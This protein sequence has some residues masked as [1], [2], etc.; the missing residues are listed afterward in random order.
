LPVLSLA[1]MLKTY[2]LEGILYPKTGVIKR[3]VFLAD[4]QKF[5]LLF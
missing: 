1:E 2:I 4:S 5:D 3:P